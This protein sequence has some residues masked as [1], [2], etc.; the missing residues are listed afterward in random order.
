MIVKTEPVRYALD[1]IETPGIVHVE[2][3]TEESANAASH[4]LNLN[5]ASHHIYTTEARKMGVRTV[6]STGGGDERDETAQC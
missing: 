3:L 4:V 6:S 2:N 1:P 5:T